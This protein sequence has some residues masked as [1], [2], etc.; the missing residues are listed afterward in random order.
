M[1]QAALITGSS[2]GIGL[3][4][5]LRC[6][7]DGANIAIAAKSVTEDPRLPGTIAGAAAQIEQAS[8]GPTG[9]RAWR[10]WNRLITPRWLQQT[11]LGSPV[12]PEVKMM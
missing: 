4:I 1:R 10:S 5:A 9:C 7:R 6:A 12:E 8:P 2:R 11:P 3:A